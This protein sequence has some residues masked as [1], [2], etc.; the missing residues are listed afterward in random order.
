MY[1]LAIL[2]FGWEISKIWIF[3]GNI[4]IGAQLGIYG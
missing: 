2:N 3:V 4:G 1:L